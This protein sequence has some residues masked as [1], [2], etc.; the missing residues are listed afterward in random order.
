MRKVMRSSPAYEFLFIFQLENIL[1][2]NL[3]FSTS[4]GLL[5]RFKVH[6][7]VITSDF[8]MAWRNNFIKI[9]TYRL[10][11]HFSTPCLDGVDF[12]HA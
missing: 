12:A 4:Y 5:D 11:G 8:F 2:S 1:R 10:G 9:F 3:K 6:I 7:R